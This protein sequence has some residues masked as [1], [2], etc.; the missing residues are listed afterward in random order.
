VH[1]TQYSDTTDSAKSTQYS[2]A[3][4]STKY[5]SKLAVLI[6]PRRDSTVTDHIT[7]KDPHTVKSLPIVTAD[8][9]RVVGTGSAVTE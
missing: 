7:V 2:D 8:T 5:H 9:D 3:T 4:D 6:V 1:S